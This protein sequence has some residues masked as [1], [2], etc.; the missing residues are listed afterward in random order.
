[1][2]K[3]RRN[4]SRL[5]VHA[6]THMRCDNQCFEGILD[7]LSIKG[8]FVAAA[9]QIGINDVVAVSIDNTLACDLIAKVVRVTDKGIGLQFEKTLRVENDPWLSISV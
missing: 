1:M 4:F 2:N 6:K 8:A 3:D 9:S 7:N 5:D